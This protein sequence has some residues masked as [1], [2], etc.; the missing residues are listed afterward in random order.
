MRNNWITEYLN[1]TE[2][3]SEEKGEKGDGTL[4]A[5]KNIFHINRLLKNSS[6]RR[7]IKNLF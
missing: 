7:S 4:F 6:S 1:A 5:V 3:F 2:M